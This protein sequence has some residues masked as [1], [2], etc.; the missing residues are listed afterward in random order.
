MIS[1]LEQHRAQD[2]AAAGADGPQQGQLPGALGHEDAER[3][4]DDE[5]ADE[6]GDAGEDQQDRRRRS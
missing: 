2:L 1:G 4:G 5:P 3:V 6:Q